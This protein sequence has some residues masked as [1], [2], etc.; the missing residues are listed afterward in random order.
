MDDDTLVALSEIGYL[1]DGP[2]LVWLEHFERF[3]SRIPFI[4]P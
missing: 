1:N 4:I 2:S 3:T